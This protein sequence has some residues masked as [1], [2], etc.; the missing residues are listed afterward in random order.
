MMSVGAHK[1]SGNL[2]VCLGLEISPSSEKSEVAIFEL[3]Q[4]DD[5]KIV[6]SYK[7]VWPHKQ[8]TNIIY[9][10][11]CG[12]VVTSF[13]GAVEIFDSVEL[14]KSVWTNQEANSMGSISALDYSEELD[15]IAFGTISGTIHFID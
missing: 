5:C 11:G 8:I 9:N 3:D 2:L 14:Y 13:R 4:K 1:V 7:F 15:I 12:L 6:N 10:H